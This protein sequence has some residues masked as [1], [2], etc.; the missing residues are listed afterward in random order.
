[1]R[2][3]SG[4]ESGTSITV[5]ITT[6]APRSAEA[7]GHFAMTLH[8][9]NYREAAMTG[10]TAASQFDEKDARWPYLHGVILQSG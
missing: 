2:A 6:L 5:T 9:H 7:W 4:S 3:S 1:M 10:Y 8:V